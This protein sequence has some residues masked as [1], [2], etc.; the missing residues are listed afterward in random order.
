MNPL[1]LTPR[2]TPRHQRLCLAGL[3]CLA[4][5]SLSGCARHAPAASAAAV[6]V[7]LP[8]HP[9]AG[10]A[11]GLR[12]PAEVAARYS[13]AMAFRVAGKI[14]ERDAHLGDLVKQGQVLARLDPSDA[15]QQAR[16]A[17]AALD[18]ATHRLSFAQQQLDRDRSQSEQNLIAAAQ[19]EQTQDAY[20]AA[21]AARDQAAAQ[22]AVARNNLQYDTLRA[23]HDGLIISEN[24]DTGQVVAA[25]QAV[26]GLAW[27]GATDV[28]IDAPES[29]L[30]LIHVGQRAIVTFPALPDRRFEAQVRE[31]APAAD[32]QS[33][34]YRVKLTLTPPDRDV[35]LGMTGQAMLAVEDSPSG[36][37]PGLNSGGAREPVFVLPATAIFHRGSQ[38]AVWIVRDTDS[39]LELRVVATNRYDAQTAT[40]TAGLRDGERV[41]LAGVHT[42][43]AG[44]LVRAVA[45]L[46]TPQDRRPDPG[47]AGNDGA[48][49]A[50]VND[51]ASR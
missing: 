27:S 11:L 13:N 30:G 46:F 2:T 16:G 49:T 43:F 33:R 38:P 25:G 40:I 4:I 29:R 9:V 41:V 44:E 22:L 39:T 12:F 45:P 48:A 7:A 15:G 50:A 18:A 19:L 26:Y 6:V 32:P 37:N 31:L 5:W 17:Q 21:L 8:V 23:E 34:T 20:T 51:A 35:R 42:V 14:I 28:T 1:P 3:S 47:S 24:A 36:T 10:D